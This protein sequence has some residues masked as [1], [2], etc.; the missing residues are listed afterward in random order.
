[1]IR[2]R[3]VE[4][5]DV[6]SALAPFALDADEFL[7][8]DVIA[9]MRRVVA[10]VPSTRDASHSLRPI[11]RK[12][13]KQNSATLV[14]ISLFAVLAKRSVDVAG[15]RE[16]RVKSEVRSQIAEVKSSEIRQLREI[17]LL[18]SDF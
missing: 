10:C 1:M 18:Q 13:S 9:I 14:G 11:I 8:I 4:A 3:M 6:L 7:G 15:N 2:M 16:H 5:D 17:L 12:L